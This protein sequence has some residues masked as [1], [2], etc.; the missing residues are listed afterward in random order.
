MNVLPH[1]LLAAVAAASGPEPEAAGGSPATAP[2]RAA[3]NAAASPRVTWPPDPAE[4][5]PDG[6]RV[7]HAEAPVYRSNVW[8][9]LLEMGVTLVGLNL[10]DRQVLGYQWAQTDLGTAGRNLGTWR[11]DDDSFQLNNLMHP[12]TGSIYYGAARSM[13]LGMWWSFGVTSLGSALWEVG[14]ETEPA[15][16]NDQIMTSVGG[17]FLGEVLYRCAVLILAGGDGDPGFWR[18]G[19]AFLVSPP[20]GANRLM[21]GDRY[22]TFDSD[23]RPTVYL[24]ATAGVGL[25]RAP[26]PGGGSGATA[27]L[28]DLHLVHGLP[29]EGGWPVQH[30]FDHFDLQLG[31]WSGERESL[32]EA[33][34]IRGML[35]ASSIQGGWNGIWGLTGLYDYA[36]PGAFHVS[37]AAL[38]VSTTGQLGARGGVALQGTALLGGGFGSAGAALGPAGSAG[39][40][41]GPA[42]QL[43]LE[44][45][46]HLGDRAA[47]GAGLRQYLVAGSAASNGLEAQHQLSLSGRLHLFGPHAVGVGWINAWRWSRSTGVPDARQHSSEVSFFYTFSTDR[48]FGARPRWSRS[49]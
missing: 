18:E 26:R 28:L 6:A 36:T 10:M 49:D 2:S 12:Y 47:I 48:A 38:G 4:V 40:H 32:V 9:P 37:S 39:D 33:L 1:L 19:A 14:G 43:V 27:A 16:I 41:R 11:F 44:S 8:V 35:A 13:G 23:P 31:L 25:E 24:E 45:R 22:R 34:F 3:L 42:A 15:S 21:F 46:L 29:G 17:S 5:S 20:T 30:P 7:L